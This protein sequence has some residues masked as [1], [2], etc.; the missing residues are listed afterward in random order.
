MSSGFLCRAR[1]RARRAAS[2]GIRTTRG[3]HAQSQQRTARTSATMS[4][5]VLLGDAAPPRQ[6]SE[7]ARLPCLVERRLVRSSEM[8][9]LAPMACLAAKLASILRLFFSTGDYHPKTARMTTETSNSYAV[10]S[11]A[12]AT[13]SPEPLVLISTGDP[14]P[15]HRA[16]QSQGTKHVLDSL[17]RRRFNVDVLHPVVW[18]DNKEITHAIP[19]PPPPSSA[20]DFHP[21]P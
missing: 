4:R 20:S 15:S 1:C 5:M 18:G 10:F 21:P 8:W 3:S 12:S 19:P 11:A 9:V 7:E 17:R 2:I 16:R 13:S 14:M 6:S